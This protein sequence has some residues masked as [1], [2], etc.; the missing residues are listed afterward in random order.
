MKFAR[1]LLMQTPN[2]KHNRKPKSGLRAETLLL[3]LVH[4]LTKKEISSIL[5]F[6]VR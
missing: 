4:T 2:M 1:Q 5:A 3:E 6:E